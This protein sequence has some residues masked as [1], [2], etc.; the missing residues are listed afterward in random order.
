MEWRNYDHD[1]DQTAVHRIWSEVGWL[2]P[3]KK[4]AVKALDIFLGAGRKLVALMDGEAECLVSTDRGSL[5]YLDEELPFAGVSGVT[6]S[7]IGRKQGFARR[8]T[9]LAVAKDVADGALVSGLGMFEQGFYNKLGFGS[10]GYEHRVSFDP[11][12][13]SVSADVPVPRRIGFD[14]WEAVHA[15]RLARTRGHGSLIFD[16][17]RL[18]RTSMMWTEKGFGLGYGDEAGTLTHMV[19]LDI[20]GD[21]GP[22]YRVVWM[23]CRDGKDFLEL[24]GLLKQLGDQ[25]RLVSM[26]EP[27]G[28][29]LQDFIERP[30]QLRAMTEGGKLEQAIR[31]FVYFQARIND[32]PGCLALTHLPVESFA[33][34]LVISDPIEACLPGDALWRGV[35]GEYVVHLGLNSKATPG[36]E[37]ALPTLT[38]SV[39]AFSRM[40]LGVRPATGLAVTDE[41][42]GPPELL[43]KLDAAFC[44]P[45]P[46]FDWDF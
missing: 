15:A 34:N 11:A 46:L 8:L 14:D 6:T 23:A 7:R 19:W 4:R 32:V 28:I 29:Q 39:N 24:M 10:C 31:A 3:D 45:H 21:H 9:A 25:V 44:L 40:W 38:T 33:F 43:A 16:D 20:S 42:I 13:M 12:R 2:S 5:R 22:H 18:T 35:A 30:N 17:P 37:P 1:H 41:L 26:N 27:P 36:T